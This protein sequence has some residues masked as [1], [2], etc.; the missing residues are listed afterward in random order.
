[1]LLLIALPA[2]AQYDLTLYEG[3][4]FS[5]T[6]TA[7]TVAGPITYQWYD[8]TNATS[9]TVGT[10]SATLT[11]TG[12]TAGTY[13]YMC[14]VANSACELPT[15]SYK[16]Q[17]LA[18]V[19]VGPPPGDTPVTLCQSCCWDGAASTWVNCY[20]T[21]N[22]Y[23]FDVV[24]YTAVSWSGNSTTFYTGASGSYSDRNGRANTAAIAST[25]ISAVQLC[26][27]LGTGWYLPAYEELANMS[28]TSGLNN[29]AGAHL[30]KTTHHW[31]STE[32]YENGGRTSSDVITNQDKAVRVY[33]NG[34]RSDSAKT[35]THHVR[36]AWR[37]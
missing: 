4:D 35:N 33:T 20:V 22:A 6:S 27:D 34:G 29:L 37:P 1:L 7:T 5:L 18:E 9:V 10:N 26:K 17:V 21:T 19:N 24:N 12:K 11:V 2:L 3:Q 15:D 36:C 31:S 32:Y 30:L 28:T 16:V 25:G 14:K 23:P 13:A 8:I